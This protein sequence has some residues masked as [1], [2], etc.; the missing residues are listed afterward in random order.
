MP[1][2][3]MEVAAYILKVD[4]DDEEIDDK[5]EEALFDKLGDRPRYIWVHSRRIVEA[6]PC[7]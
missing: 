7:S 5:V 4:L 1:D 3:A 2:D 6:D